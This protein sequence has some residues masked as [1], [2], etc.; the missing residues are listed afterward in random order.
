MRRVE[1]IDIVDADDDIA[2][3]ET[4]DLRRS[5]RFDGR[6]DHGPRAVDAETELSRLSA[7]QHD[8]VTF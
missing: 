2:D 7:H 3:V 6:H 5:G 1:H 8:I 4:G